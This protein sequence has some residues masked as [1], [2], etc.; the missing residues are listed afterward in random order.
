VLSIR[1]TAVYGQTR[2]DIPSLHRAGQMRASTAARSVSPAQRAVSPLTIGVSGGQRMPS[3]SSGVVKRS[4]VLSMSRPQN[5]SVPIARNAPANGVSDV[6][7]G[8]ANVGALS[9][10]AAAAESVRREESRA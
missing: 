5:G 3:L 8:E 2:S 10:P 9:A 7:V 6:S 4:P 1:T